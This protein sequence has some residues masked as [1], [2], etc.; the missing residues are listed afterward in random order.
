M[1]LGI[2]GFAVRGGLK[3][4]YV[5]EARRVESRREGR[6]PDV[7]TSIADVARAW[8]RWP[9][10]PLAVVSTGIMLLLTTPF[11]GVVAVFVVFLLRGDRR[12]ASIAAVLIVALLV[13]LAFINR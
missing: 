12:Y 11:A 10:E 9:V 2:V 1:T 5:A 6:A 3:A 4:E 7:Y 8:R 13:S